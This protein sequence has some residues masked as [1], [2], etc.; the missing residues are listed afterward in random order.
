MTASDQ[1]IND[2]LTQMTLEEK[3]S[4]TIGQD[5][6]STHPVERLGLGS[7]NM[8][9]GPHGL[10][11]PPENSSIG[12]IDAIPATCFPTAAAV[13][14][15][16][17]VDLTKAIGEA[18]AQEC[19]ANNV[20]IVLGPG[21]NLK[22][23]PLGG[24]NFEYYSED[25]VLA[26]E[27]GTAF[28]EGV[29]SHGVGTS[30]KHYACNNQEFERMTISS[31]VDQRTLREL[32]LAAFERVVKRAQP[33]TIMAA[34][35][36]INGIYATEHRQLLTEILR[37]EWG[38]EGIV[39]SDWG[40]VNDKAAA[41]TAGLD[42][43]M[44]GP[45]LNHVEFL[46]GLV[47]KGALS[48]TVIDT[49]ASRMLKIILRGIAQRQ[50][51]ASYDKAAHHALARR[52]ASE[53]MVLL[54]NDGILPLQPTAGSTV[55]VIGNFA[56]KPRYQGAGSSEI[57]AT[58]VDTPLE[59]LQTW[60]KNQSVEVNFAAG[61]DHDGNTNDQLIAEA[62]AAAKNASLSLVLVGLP[63]AYETEGADRAHMNMPTGH[64]Q[65]LE[66][67][68]AVQANTVAILINGSAV[69]IPW[70][71][72]V[73]AVLE[74]GLAGQAVGSALVDVLSGAVN[75]SGK[76]AETFPY[77]LADTPAFLNYPGEAGVVRYGESLF[78]GYRYYDVR[79]VKPLFPFGYGLSYTSFRYD[80]IAL[81]AASI[82]EAT[83]LTV[84][85][86][87]T[88][89]GE[90]VGKEVV[91]VYVK[92]SNS[93][94]LRPVKE[95]RAFAKV[96]LAAGETKTVELTL[97]ARDF[98]LYDQQRAAW[99]MEGGSYQ[100]LAGGCSADLPLVA[101]LTVNED[102]RS[103]RKVLTRM[104][105]IK[106]FLDDPI[107]AEILHATAGAFIEGQSASTRAIFEPIPLAKF[108]NFGFF[109]A[110]QVDEIVAKVN[111]G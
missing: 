95:L 19:L 23:T 96:E 93:A 87:L 103:A 65:L 79:K 111:Q 1:Q 7:I 12:I 84:S 34:Y 90:R 63:D 75:P 83:P 73:R 13:A 20:Q 48:E 43:E 55:A 52:A 99:R 28:V 56:Q 86:T 11:K 110:S 57:N 106:E 37:E 47:R 92:P 3:I 97:V 10:R 78:I 18:I 81:S 31:E 35:N 102:P 17:D 80:Q 36:K 38:F 77:D 42:L 27:L 15:T 5:M 100:I 40:A 109:E 76:L 25:P 2:L 64:N 62:V 61:Y 44:P 74:A 51:A 101:D 88:N 16:W 14:S 89:T 107:G 70:L 104:S 71:D 30:L 108:V 72:Q 54:K 22:R 9:D 85:V 41:L 53:S 21:I 98:S 33:W 8:N 94:Y 29:Q 6:W 45:A 4:L 32:Y 91:Q 67:V 60:L 69:T 66:A 59:A 105:S 24:R 49:A 39:V 58:Q 50:P 82:D 26:G 46:A 68:A